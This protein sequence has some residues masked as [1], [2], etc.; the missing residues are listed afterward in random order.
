MGDPNNTIEPYNITVT[1]YLVH[2]LKVLD[3]FP[4]SFVSIFR[5]LGFIKLKKSQIKESIYNVWI[6]SS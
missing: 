4:F 5:H 2:Y 3:F 1:I 6:F